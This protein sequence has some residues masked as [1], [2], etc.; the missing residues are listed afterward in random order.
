MS[1]RK[2]KRELARWEAA[3]R[4]WATVAGR[5]LA[6]DLHDHRQVAVRQ[7][8]VGLV[9]QE[10]EQP[11]VEVPVTC[12][13]DAPLR[14]GDG[15][16]LLQT[17][18]WLVTSLRVA[19]RLHPD[20]LRWWTWDQVIGV[21]VNLTHGRERVCIDIAGAE[22]VYFTGPGV[23]PLAVAA[24]YRLHGPLAV[25]EHPGLAPLRSSEMS[26]PGERPQKEAVLVPSAELEKPKPHVTLW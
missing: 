22:P 17:G 26:G 10:G 24:I 21:Q 15:R 9:L 14:V 3:T 11:W 8:T 13:A 2:Q 25:I 16:S 6:L 7:Y 5:S 1:I 12:S 4:Q 20:I 18:P 19:G 23:A